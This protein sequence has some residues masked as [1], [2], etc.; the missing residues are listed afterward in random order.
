MQRVACPKCRQ[1]FE[2]DSEATTLEC[3]ACGTTLRRNPDRLAQSQRIGRYRLDALIAAGEQGDVFRGVDREA[4]IP[5]AIK[6]QSFG[7]SARP[8]DAARFLREARLA[9]MIQSPHVVRILDCGEWEGKI[10][11]VMEV[12]EGRDLSELV[13]SSGPCPLDFGIMAA[14]QAGRGVAAV[15]AAGIVHRD[16]KPANLVFDAPGK[17]IVLTDF[18]MAKGEAEEFLTQPGVVLGTPSTMAP[19]LAHGEPASPA[20]DQY[21][22]GVTIWFLLA[23]RYPY[24]DATDMA[25]ILK[26]LHD[27][28]PDLR[29]ARPDCPETLA[30]VVAKA[31]AKD[32]EHRHG[33]VA[34]LV[35]RLVEVKTTPASPPASGAPREARKPPRRRPKR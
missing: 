8:T 26:H 20:S 33:S 11:V 4:D 34:E 29:D 23:G 19:E 2:A 13:R 17:R 6:V 15:H 31:M 35:D 25:V 21:G 18:G 7:P 22:L 10:F 5:V 16:V 3:P 27:P 24:E 28:I 12:V 14:I 9:A 1:R 32:P 30:D